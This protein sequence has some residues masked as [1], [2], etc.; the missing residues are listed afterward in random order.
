ML[1][2]LENDKLMRSEMV[3]VMSEAMQKEIIGSSAN[4]TDYQPAISASVPA[5][6]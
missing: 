5:F 3:K 6:L 1:N 4:K 2:K